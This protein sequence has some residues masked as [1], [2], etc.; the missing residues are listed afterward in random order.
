M[1]TKFCYQSKTK[2]VCLFGKFLFYGLY[3]YFYSSNVSDISYSIKYL[4][5]HQG[6]L[7]QHNLYSQ[8]FSFLWLLLLSTKNEYIFGFNPKSSLIPMP[9]VSPFI[10]PTANFFV[11]SPVLITLQVYILQLYKNNPA[12]TFCCNFLKFFG[13]VIFLRTHLRNYFWKVSTDYILALAQVPK[14]N[15]MTTI[16]SSPINNFIFQ[17]LETL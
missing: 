17:T 10:L 5:I 4:C 7:L 8:T 14:L 9:P 12:L 13:A 16:H 11:N 1:D 15:K 2:K 6:L 3:F